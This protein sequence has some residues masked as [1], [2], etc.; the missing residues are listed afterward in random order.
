MKKI[1]SLIILSLG[2]T[3]TIAQTDTKPTDDNKL[4]SLKAKAVDVNNIAQTD[5]LKKNE[6]GFTDVI[7]NPATIV[8]HQ[9]KT[10]TCWSFSGTS[11]V[12]SQSLKNCFHFKK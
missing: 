5:F 11:L 6:K 2:F 8:K 4:A 7:I 9:E 10:N 12:E 3:I 1:F